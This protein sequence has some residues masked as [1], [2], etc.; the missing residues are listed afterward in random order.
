MHKI[1]EQFYIDNRSLLVNRITRR[2]GSPENAE[3]VVQ[4]AF[5]RALKYKDSFDPNRQEIGAWFNT[6]LNNTL[7]KFKR[8]E[9]VGGMALEYEEDKH[10]ES[11]TMSETDSD[12][13]KKI[14]EEISSKSG[15]VRD[16]LHLY[17]E[18]EYKPTEI[19]E[20]LNIPY[21]TIQSYIY[22]FKGEMM[23]EFGDD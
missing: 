23:G 1:I 3:D 20:V 9:I 18:K 17:F 22:R 21:R 11:Y 2:A 4:D 12:L 7:V 8:I 5:E 14:S 16:V 15:D 19:K 10:A 13:V 6:I